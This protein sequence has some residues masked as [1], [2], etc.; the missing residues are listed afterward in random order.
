MNFCRH[1]GHVTTFSRML[2]IACCLVTGLGFKI[3]L[4]SGWLVYLY[5]F[6]AVIV[7]HDVDVDELSY[8]QCT[9]GSLVMWA[10]VFHAVQCTNWCS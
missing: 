4:G 10:F 5:D 1:V 7:Q 9:T 2:T 6:Y 8:A 3:G